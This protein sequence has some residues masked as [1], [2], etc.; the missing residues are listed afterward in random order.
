M[1]ACARCC[2]VLALAALLQLGLLVRMTV[3]WPG[4]RDGFQEGAV[5][6]WRN[7]RVP[8][9]NRLLDYL[10][11]I[12]FDLA[13]IALCP[14]DGSD[15]ACVDAGRAKEAAS[16][17]GFNA[18]PGYDFEA[19]TFPAGARTAS[20]VVLRPRRAHFFPEAAGAD[21]RGGPRVVVWF[22]GGGL[23]IGGAED[24]YAVPLVDALVRRLGPARTLVVAS[25]EYAL[26]PERPFPAAADDA[27][28]ALEGVLARFPDAAHVS[29]AGASA[30]AYLAL[31]AAYRGRAAGLRVDSLFLD[32][33]FLKDGHCGG[34]APPRGEGSFA[35]N[36]W[37]R[38]PSTAWLDWSWRAYLAGRDMADYAMGACDADNW[39]SVGGPPPAVILTGS[40]DPLR[41]AAHELA[42]TY[43]A[44]G[45]AATL[46]EARAAHCVAFLFDGAAVARAHNLYAD[47]LLGECAPG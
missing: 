44:A 45:G 31:V 39:R 9:A 2:A 35:A 21:A 3:R 16:R 13:E 43:A 17:A 22:H 8:L 30:G 28:A 38:L 36:G 24:T 34:T 1:A 27:L 40:G 5:P 12:S 23:N 29:V 20:A 15:V 4:R 42:A 25:V 11:P 46:V 33:P 14:V 18:T 6:V 37:M 41:D 32:S 26:A 7:G 10:L 47:L 19:W